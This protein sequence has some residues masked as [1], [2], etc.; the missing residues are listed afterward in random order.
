MSGDAVT[1]WPLFARALHWLV[2]L[3]VIIEVPLGFWM[4]ELA[5]TQNKTPGDDT[6]IMPAINAHHTIGF[7]ILILAVLRVNWRLNNPIPDLPAYMGAYQRLLSRSTQAFLYFLMFF[8][9]LTGWAA[10]AT[11]SEATPVLFFGWEIP[12]MTTQPSGAENFTYDLFT[13]L[14]QVCWKIGGVLL[15]LHITGA[16]WHQFIKK[17]DVLARMWSGTG[18]DQHKQLNNQEK[19]RKNRRK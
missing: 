7:L 8:Y 18:S 1:G 2:A 6:W 13:S 14:H 12:R 19:I 5:D 15:A 11:S 10:V 16:L 4:L 3:L 9:P 17:E